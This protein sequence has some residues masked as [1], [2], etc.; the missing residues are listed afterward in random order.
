MYFVCFQ[1]EPG[2]PGERGL[3]GQQGDTGLPGPPVRTQTLD[4]TYC[5]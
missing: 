4:K 2:D 1:G 3:P 5:S